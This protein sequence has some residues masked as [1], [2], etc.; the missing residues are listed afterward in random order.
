[1]SALQ[2]SVSPLSTREIRHRTARLANG[3]EIQAEVDAGAHTAAIGFFVR[4]GARDEPTELMGVSHFLEHMMFK[5]SERRRAEDVNREFDELGA[6]HNAFTT[7][8]LTAYY[9]HVLPER[10]HGALEILADILRPALRQEDFDEEK[11]VIL[12]E[13]A[14]YA[15]QPFWVG[16][17]AMMER[18]YAGHPLE[19]RV[20]GTTQ[21]VGALGR[22]QMADYFDRRYSADNTV[23]VAAGRVDFD[24]LVRE[25]ERLC[26]HWNTARPTREHP[27]WAPQPATV[28]LQLPNT[29][30]AYVILSM[31]A[32][33]IQDDMRYASGILMHVL[34]GGD[35]SRL[36][37]ALVETGLAEEASAS[38]DGHDGTGDNTLFAVCDP[39]KADEIEG[40]LRAELAA[41]LPS[42]TDD[43]LLRA[44]SRIATGAA[45]GSERPNGRMFRLGTLWGYGAEYCTLEDEVERISRVTL[46]DLRACCERFPLDPKVSVHVLPSPDSPAAK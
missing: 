7:N 24:A 45:V 17:E 30:R 42:I 1:M 20:L 41:L 13:I 10:T 44:R 12:E 38:Y 22:D 11:Q 2:N 32:P 36:H 25:A 34:G 39:A 35:G 8:E 27:R 40:V 18:L 6:A 43:D 5:G 15:D 4:T 31:P 29:A 23:L 46:A 14:M 21:S 19:H 33:A 28:R 37:W 3:L 9:A 16:Y 26:G